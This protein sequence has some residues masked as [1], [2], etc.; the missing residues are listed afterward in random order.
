MCSQIKNKWNLLIWSNIK[1]C[2]FIYTSIVTV[3]RVSEN[4]FTFYERMLLLAICL[5]Y[6][7]SEFLSQDPSDPL[8][9]QMAFGDEFGNDEE[10]MIE[11]MKLY[12]TY[13]DYW[14][15]Q[16]TA[17]MLQRNIEIIN[18]SPESLRDGSRITCM[19]GDSSPGSGRS[20]LL[21]GYLC[22]SL[23][24]VSL[25]EYTVLDHLHRP[26]VLLSIKENKLRS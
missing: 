2:V 3:Y 23:H 8:R 22:D 13:A 18:S 24:Y 6:D 21:I 12:E 14:I 5:H 20:P 25:C 10:T 1:V 11:Q 7:R 26:L 4:K 15:I 17:R 9:E 16:G 19:I